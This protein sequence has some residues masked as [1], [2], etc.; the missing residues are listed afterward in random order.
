MQVI[1]IEMGEAG[2]AR[3]V[4]N[5]H[6]TALLLD[7]T[8][9]TEPAHGTRDVH[10][11]QA[12]GVGEVC[13]GHRQDEIVVL[14]AKRAGETALQFQQQVRDPLAGRAPANADN[15]FPE[16]GLF[17]DRCPPEGRGKLPVGP[18]RGDKGGIFDLDD[19]RTGD[20]GSMKFTI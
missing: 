7:K 16:D 18:Q 11:R 14:A 5:R 8:G 17:L 10:R 2:Q 15:L 20:G 3:A 4:H 12:E 9:G 1:I 6:D 13:P 19:A